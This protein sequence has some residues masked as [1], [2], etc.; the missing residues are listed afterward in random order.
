MQ[1]HPAPSARQQWLATLPNGT[2]PDTCPPYWP[3]GQLTPQQQRRHAAQVRA[4]R[5]G[6]LARFP[7]ALL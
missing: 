1:Q 7:A 4:M 5:E 2:R 6:R 3:F